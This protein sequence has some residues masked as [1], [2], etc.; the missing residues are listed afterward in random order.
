[1]ADM[2]QTTVNIVESLR[3]THGFPTSKTPRRGRKSEPMR[4]TA[5]HRSQPRHHLRIPGRR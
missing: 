1:M 3:S 4:Q 2:T 5:S